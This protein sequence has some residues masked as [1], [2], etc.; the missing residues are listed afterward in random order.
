MT[1]AWK[2]WLGAMLFL[3]GGGAF[4]AWGIHDLAAWLDALG[5]KA[6]LIETESALLGLAPLGIAIAAVG[7][8]LPITE[9]RL[10]RHRWIVTLLV[11]ATLV[12]MIAGL[13]LGILGGLAIDAVMRSRD[14]HV[15]QV[16]HGTRMS[17]TTWAAPGTPCPPEDE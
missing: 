14:Y 2:R 5:R 1:P 7:G 12:L 8:F 15:C 10:G 11:G 16:R 13:V 9:I 17:F 4:A 3:L 6:A